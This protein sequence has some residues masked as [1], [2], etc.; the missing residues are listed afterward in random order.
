MEIDRTRHCSWWRL[1]VLEIISQLQSSPPEIRLILS[2][3]V[4]LAGYFLS[5]A[6]SRAIGAKKLRKHGKTTVP[7]DEV[8]QLSRIVEQI[9]YIVTILIALF[10]INAPILNSF[11]DSL[12]VS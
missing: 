10:L 1:V 8:I 11:M 6:L 12:I 3:F 9:G 4:L 7:S 2:I 5:G